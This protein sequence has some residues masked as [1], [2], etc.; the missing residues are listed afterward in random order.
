MTVKMSSKIIL[1]WQC[2]K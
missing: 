2:M 1:W